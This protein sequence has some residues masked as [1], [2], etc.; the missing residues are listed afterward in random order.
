MD[1]AGEKKVLKY[2]LSRIN[3]LY[4]TFIKKITYTPCYKYVLFLFY[5]LKNIIMKE[6]L[7]LKTVW[8]GHL[9]KAIELK[10]PS[11]ELEMIRWFI[12]DIDRMLS[13]QK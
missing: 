7:E 9:E 3:T 4:L 1:V 2:F 8:L 12:R 5:L 6:L 11:G 13:K 10:S